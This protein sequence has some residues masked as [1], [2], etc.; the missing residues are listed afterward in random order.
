MTRKTRDTIQLTL[1]P[2]QADIILP[3]GVTIQQALRQLKIAL[4]YPCGGAGVC[5]KCKIK[6]LKGAPDAGYQEKILLS[7]REL[8]Q[9]IRLACLSPLNNDCAVEIPDELRLPTYV[10]REKILHEEIALRP[11]VQKLTLNVEID[12]LEKYFSDLDLLTRALT[13]ILPPDSFSFS[14]EALQKLPSALR[15]QSGITTI[16]LFNSEIIDIEAGDTSYHS[17]ALAVDLGTTTIGLLLIHLPTGETIDYAVLPNPQISFG[18]DLISRISHAGKGQQELIQL[19]KAVSEALVEIIEHLCLQHQISPS[20][21]YLIAIAGNTV[22][23]QI[24]WGI[25][26]KYVGLSPF[27]PTVQHLLVQKAVDFPAPISKHTAVLSFPVI[28]GFVGGDTVS[29]LL[30]TEFHRIPEDES[31]LLIDIGTNCEV[32]LAKGNKLL[33]ASAPAGPALEGAKISQGMRAIPGAIS[34]L[35]IENKKLK[36]ITIDDKAPVGICGSGLFHIIRF[37][38][39][40]GVINPDGSINENPSDSFWKTRID[41]DNNDVLRILLVSEEEG[42]ET[43]VYLTQKDIR[44]FQ[45]ANGAIGSAWCLLCKQM[46]IEPADID[47]IFVAGAFGN[48]I[49]PEAMIALG[50]IPSIAKEK[51][52]FAGN[53]SL[54]GVRQLILNRRNFEL[55]KELAKRVRFVELANLPEFQEVFVSKLRLEPRSG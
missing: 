12:R 2:E 45:L 24:F 39:D 34:D 22:M 31:R 54:E 23:T 10:A 55:I 35:T 33:A 48:Y 21:L 14:P 50:T 15:D 47:R 19:K 27:R 32:V 51:I 8:E 49:R 1:I 7:T 36:W 17:Y 44:E 43:S 52:R 29:D 13:D 25:N 30:T 20:H 53:A 37:L 16:T 46:E 11:L 6:F 40:E 9:G 26:P 41:S 42:A 28:G 5:G 3:K 38:R 4:N 18:A